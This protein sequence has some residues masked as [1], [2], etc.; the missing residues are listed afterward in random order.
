M[1]QELYQVS[2]MCYCIK[3]YATSDMPRFQNALNALFMNCLL[4]VNFSVLREAT[5]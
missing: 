5:Q 2:E 1:A 4:S 3:Y